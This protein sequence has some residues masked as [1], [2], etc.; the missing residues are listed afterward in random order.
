MAPRL[1]VSA[2]VNLRHPPSP[3]PITNPRALSIAIG[4][5]PPFYLGHAKAYT[6]PAIRATVTTR[7]LGLASNGTFEVERSKWN[8]RNATFEMEHSKCSIRWNIKRR[9]NNLT[10]C[11][12]AFIHSRTCRRRCRYTHADGDGAMETLGLFAFD[13]V[14]GLGGLD[15][16]DEAV[17][18]G[19]LDCEDAGCLVGDPHAH[20]GQP[21]TR[22]DIRSNI[23]SNGRCDGSF[24]GRSDAT[25]DA[26]FDGTDAHS[27]TG[28]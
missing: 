27:S 24:D 4:A 6:D 7:R 21:D 12:R 18:V 26:T 23:R 14:V 2:G 28:V 9:G 11:D 19:G 22:R 25:L 5:G 20:L 3:H 10:V 17:R 16:D 13:V 8:I 15:D 1:V